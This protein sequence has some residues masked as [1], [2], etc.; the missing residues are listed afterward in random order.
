MAGLARAGRLVGAGAAGRRVVI[1]QVYGVTTP[2]DAALVVDAGADN[3]GVVRDEGYG[4][5]DGVDDATA[6]AIVKE[7]GA[8]TTVALSLA[9]DAD[10]IVRTLDVVDA[11]VAHLVRV[12]ETWSPGTVAAFRARIAP[13]RL[14]CTIGVRDERAL[15]IARRF[16]G[17]C[18]YFLLDTAHP[19]TDVV[20]ATGLVH[21]WALSARLVAAVTTPVFLAGGLG[22][23]N[24][25]D[26]VAQVRPY[27]VDSET[28]TSRAGDRRRKDPEKVRRFVEVAREAAR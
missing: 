16:D 21:D 6:R 13:V 3:V 14:M 19:G 2:D 8:V 24:V 18:D 5:W 17:S 12:T 7:L 15:D 11:Q 1:V 4:T 26:A 10:E 20:G 23:E 28:R 27:G 25:A 22:P 9:T